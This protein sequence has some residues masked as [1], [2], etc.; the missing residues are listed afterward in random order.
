MI[1]LILF[2]A[3]YHCC[4]MFLIFNIL[5]KHRCVKWP[6]CHTQPCVHS[7]ISHS[8]HALQHYHSAVSYRGGCVEDPGSARNLTTARPGPT[9]RATMVTA[10]GVGAAISLTWTGRWPLDMDATSCRSTTPGDGPEKSLEDGYWC[11]LPSASLASLHPFLSY[12]TLGIKSL[13]PLSSDFP[14]RPLQAPGPYR[15]KAI[16]LILTLNS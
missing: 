14:S 10:R 9:F 2:T 11:S 5:F 12:P 16:T 15:A 4:M 13:I 3:L 1:V 6:P 8:S 7:F